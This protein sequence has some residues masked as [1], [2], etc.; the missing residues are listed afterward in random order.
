MPSYNFANRRC[1]L[2]TCFFPPSLALNKPTEK[3]SYELC[4]YFVLFCCV[5]ALTLT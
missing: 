5:C 2:N 1:V 3:H 4:V